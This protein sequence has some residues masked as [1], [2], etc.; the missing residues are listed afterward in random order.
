[1]VGEQTLDVADKYGVSPGRISQKRREFCQDWRSFCGERLG[2][3]AASSASGVAG[4]RRGQERLRSLRGI[5]PDR[6]RPYGS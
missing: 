4:A 3:P 1:M 2:G 5:P 6:S